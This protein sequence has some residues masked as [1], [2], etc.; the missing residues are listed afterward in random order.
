LFLNGASSNQRRG[1]RQKT[2]TPRRTTHRRAEPGP[3]LKR[4]L[5]DFA[6]DFDFDVVSPDVETVVVI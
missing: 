6:F 2:A 5:F 1:T 3:N 4:R